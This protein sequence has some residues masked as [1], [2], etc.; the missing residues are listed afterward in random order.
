VAFSAAGRFALTAGADERVRIW[1]LETGDPVG[2][3]GE[4]DSAR[5]QPWLQSS[6]PG[7][8]LFRKC[9]GCHALTVDERQRSGPH[10][11]GLFGRRAGA[12]DGYRYSRAL[13][14]SELVWGRE[15]LSQLFRLGP[16][17]YLPGTKMPVQ[18]IPNEADLGNLI[19]YLEL[20][21]GRG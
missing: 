4:D 9:A 20:I 3:G 15:T 11:A 12:V 17:H 14:G 1:H 16:D 6:H 13:V 10:F 2:V 19:D 7:A 18:R 8:R 5:P 21:I